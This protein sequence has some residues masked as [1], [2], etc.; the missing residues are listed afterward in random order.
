MELHLKISDVLGKDEEGRHILY[1]DDESLRRALLEKP[2]W[3][4][5]SVVKGFLMKHT[6]LMSEC[7]E[8]KGVRDTIYMQEKARRDR[9]RAEKDAM[10]LEEERRRREKANRKAAAIYDKSVGFY[11]EMLAWGG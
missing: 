11:H 8:D 9:A 1:V 6:A 10:M 5:Q 2:K 7:I 3:I 4:M